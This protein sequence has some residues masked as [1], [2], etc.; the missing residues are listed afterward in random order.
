[1]GAFLKLELFT[2]GQRSECSEPESGPKI[3]QV[4][5]APQMGDVC[6]GLLWE[7]YLGMASRR[8]NGW[9]KPG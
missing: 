8:R 6:E 3:A 9:R 5:V 7:E 4:V 2:P 1:M